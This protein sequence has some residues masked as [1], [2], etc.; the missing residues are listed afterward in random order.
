MARKAKT[1]GIPIW[2]VKESMVAENPY[3]PNQP[4]SFCIPWGKNTT[5]S[6]TLRTVNATSSYVC[7]VF[8][9]MTTSFLNKAS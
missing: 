7:K 9:I 8:L 3:P 5:P 6:K 4:R 1:A 2:V